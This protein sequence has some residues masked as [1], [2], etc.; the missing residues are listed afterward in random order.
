MINDR[1]ID[2]SRLFNDKTAEDNLA[3][4]LLLVHKRYE[5]FRTDLVEKARQNFKLKVFYS[6][7]NYA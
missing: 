2:E 3:A 6:S 4:L 5:S 1:I 7:L